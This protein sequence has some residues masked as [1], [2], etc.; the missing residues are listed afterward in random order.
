MVRYLEVAT[1]KEHE[2]VPSCLGKEKEHACFV[3]ERRM[4]NDPNHEI[5]FTLELSTTSQITTRRRE[6][7]QTEIL[8]GGNSR[9]C[10][11]HS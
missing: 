11:L 2:K 9:R 3:R 5:L 1:E 10:F 7:D 8:S 4:K 6:R